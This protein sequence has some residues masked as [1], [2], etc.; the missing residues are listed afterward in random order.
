MN[1]T[2]VFL[3][4][5]LWVAL[6][7]SV[8]SAQ[9]REPMIKLDA[10]PVYQPRHYPF[11]AGEKEV[12]RA[13][14]NGIFSVATAEIQ[15]TPAVVDGRKVYQVRVDAKTSRVLDM[16]WKMRDTI[17]STFDAKALAPSHFNFSQ[18]ENSRVI[19]TDA[20]YDHGTK[21]WAVN[22]QQ[23]GKRAK[24]YQFDSDN[25]LDPITAIY[26][27]RSTDFKVGDRLYFKLFGGRYRYLL[28]LFIEKKEPVE[29]ESGKV[30]E[31]Y[32]VIPR[33]Q[34]TTKNGYA[35][36]LNDAVIWLSADHRR[37]PIKLSSK[38]VFGSVYLDL[39]EAKQVPQSTANESA[40]PAS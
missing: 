19:D 12:Y 7:P 1:K 9:T 5:I 38:I 25:T 18:R 10:V 6:A 32:R 23:V 14:W 16:I 22:R 27:A 36:R 31:A 29:L 37:L 34:N 15:A 21:R 3:V 8:F 24:I 28:E 39:I 13:S 11:E 17:T 33:I 4:A 2:R 20:K 30:V 35:G 40:R 26:L